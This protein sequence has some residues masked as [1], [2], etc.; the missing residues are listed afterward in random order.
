M[1]KNITD[2]PRHIGKTQVE[3]NIDLLIS[4]KITRNILEFLGGDEHNYTKKKHTRPV[5]NRTSRY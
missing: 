4:D 2:I 3:R 1:N 5:R